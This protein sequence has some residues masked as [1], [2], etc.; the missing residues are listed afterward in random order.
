MLLKDDIIRRRDQCDLNRM[1]ELIPN[2]RKV[3]LHIS[4]SFDR[5]RNSLDLFDV[6]VFDG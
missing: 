6:R 4:K 2:F 5:L 3:T 1:K